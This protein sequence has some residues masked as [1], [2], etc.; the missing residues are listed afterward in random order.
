MLFRLEVPG[1]DGRRE[2]R[3]QIQVYRVLKEAKKKYI[4]Y[5]CLYTTQEIEEVMEKIE[6][7]HQQK[8]KNYTIFHR[9]SKTSVTSQMQK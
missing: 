2:R 7:D 9:E 8:T 4:E 1:L 5:T 6:K 3:Y